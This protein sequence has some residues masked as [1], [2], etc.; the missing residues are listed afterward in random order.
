MELLKKKQPGSAMDLVQITGE[1]SSRPSRGAI[2][3]IL[4]VVAMSVGCWYTYF[5]MFPNPVNDAASVLLTVLMPAVLYFLCRTPI[6]GRFLVFYTFILIAVYFVMFYESVWN[7]FLVMANIVVEVLNNQMDAGLIPFEITGDVVDWS[8]DTLM[9]MIPVLLVESVSIVYSVYYKEPL[10]GFV[11]TAFPVVVG[12]Y[13]EAEPSIWLLILMLLCWTGLLVL[14]AV[15]K[16][17]SRKKHRP[18]YIQNQKTSSLPYI[19]LSITLALFLGYVLIFSGDDYRP[20]QSVDKAKAAV[21]AA[22]EHLRYDKLNGADIDQL[23]HGDLTQTHPLEYTDNTVLKLRMQMVQPM[24]LRGFVGGCFENEKWS[25]AAEGAYSGEYTGIMEWLAQQGFYPWMQQERMYRMSENYDFISVEAENLNT[26]SKYMYLPYEAAMSGDTLPDNVNYEKDYAAK[27]KGI[28]G[29]RNYSFKAF[30]PRMGDYDEGKIVSWLAEVKRSEDWDSYA[31]AEA[32]YR[33]YIYDTYP[34]VNQDDY[35]LMKSAGVEKCQGKTIEYTLHYIRKLFDDEYSYS[36]EK[37]PA[38]SGESELEYF[39][40]QSHEGGDMHFTTMAALMFRCAGIPARYA[41]GYYISPGKA[42][43]YSEMSDVTLNVLDSDAHSWVELYIDE[44]GWFP[45][46]IIPGYYEMD[47][48]QSQETEESEKLEERPKSYYQDEIPEY[49]Q[50]EKSQEKE[51]T[52][53]SPLWLIIPALLLLAAIVELIG[54]RKIR[55]KLNSFGTVINDDKVYEMYKYTAKLMSFDKH[56][57]P[58]DPYDRLQEISDCYN[59]ATELSFAEF[60]RMVNRLRFG[61]ISLNKEEHKKMA[62]YAVGIGSHIYS[63]QG[64]FRKFIMKYIIFYV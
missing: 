51:E 27:T 34:Y 38:P 41:E 62:G 45:V 31:E 57:I 2:F 55:S 58:A 13:L 36:I 8:K 43:S 49:D 16:P 53:R 63:K 26:S 33:R 23:S 29:Q 18:I 6:V 42:E 50:P 7:G 44:V 54:R 11:F 48:Q 9:A 1:G 64:R 5:S 19:F 17:V 47:R 59:H 12:L 10:I 52:R 61:N 28:A 15:G 3:E 60:I 24:Y 56:P 39:I 21:I 22:E 46:E 35:E 4:L 20:P 40:T 25:E 14:S 32:V 30:M 37:E